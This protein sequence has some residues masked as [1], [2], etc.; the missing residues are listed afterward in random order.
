MKRMFL[1]LMCLLFTSGAFAQELDIFEAAISDRPLTITALVNSGKDVNAKDI[2]GTT[3]LMYAALYGNT[4]TVIVLITEL[5]ATVDVTD[6]LCGATALMYAA[7]AGRTE[8]AK[9]LVSYGAEI[10]LSDNNGM[11][12]LMYAAR[13]GYTVT[14]KA[15][16]NLGADIT[17]T[18][19]DGWTA[20]KYAEF[21]K[22][23]ETAAKL[24]KLEAKYRRKH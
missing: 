20:S 16:V 14:A 10:N 3:P 23:P 17:L 2:S 24:K 19:K 15:L 11:T 7:R 13:G 1:V 6:K 5:K 18:D 4:D 21:F 9:T 8:T 22:F 12:A